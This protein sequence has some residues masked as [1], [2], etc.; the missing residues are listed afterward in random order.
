VR[1]RFVECERDGDAVVRD[2]QRGALEQ[3]VVSLPV[4]YLYLDSASAE[5]ETEGQ[6][7]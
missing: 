4:V 2:V 6:A 3:G 7:G 5:A 1:Y